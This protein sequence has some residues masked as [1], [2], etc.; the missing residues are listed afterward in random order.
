[1]ARVGRHQAL[2]LMIVSWGDKKAGSGKMRQKGVNAVPLIFFF[3]NGFT[4]IVSEQ[5]EGSFFHFKRGSSLLAHI[6]LNL[7]CEFPGPG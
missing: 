5:E 3:S 4:G 2:T 6:L 7:L 1:M